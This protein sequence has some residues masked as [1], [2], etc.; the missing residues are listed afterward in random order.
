MTSVLKGDHPLLQAHRPQPLNL[1]D[2]E[3]LAERIIQ[4][5]RSRAQ[6]LLVQAQEQGEQVRHSAAEAG[7]KEGYEKGYREGTDRGREEALANAAE[8]FARDQAQLLEALQGALADFEQQRTQLLAGAR[9]EL[10]RLALAI[11]RRVTKRYAAGDPQ[12][13]V[14][15][16]KEII[17]RVGQ[18]H[19][20]QIAVHPADAESIRRLAGQL[21][22]ASQRWQNVGLTEDAEIEPGGCRVSLPDGRIDASM[23]TQLERIAAALL[24]G[25]QAT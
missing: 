12:V 10:V 7:R 23:E 20:L 16:L 18:R 8:Q 13:A 14:E 17:E 25:D 1:D 2:L 21:A 19:L 15:N 6:E 11:A 5:A 9:D 24:P 22:E 3:A 4:G